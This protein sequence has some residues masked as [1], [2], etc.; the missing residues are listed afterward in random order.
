MRKG[1]I[2]KV[3]VFSY[4]LAL[5]LAGQKES[6]TSVLAQGNPAS[7]WN[8]GG[9]SGPGIR[10]PPRPPPPKFPG[11]PRAPHRGAPKPKRHARS[12]P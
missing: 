10:P 2:F 12:R 9:R 3:F 1:S 8:G 4:V 7:P 6:G 5:M 11:R